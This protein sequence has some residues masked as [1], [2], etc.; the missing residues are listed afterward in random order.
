MYVGILQV[1]HSN[2]WGT[3][4]DDEWNTN[5]TRVVCRQLGYQH[6]IAKHLGPGSGRIWLD[7]VVCSGNENS[8]VNCRHRG[9]GVEDCEH[10]EDIG[11]ACFTGIKKHFLIFFLLDMH[12][13]GVHDVQYSLR[14]P[15]VLVTSPNWAFRWGHNP[16][17]HAGRLEVRYHGTWGTL[18][19]DNIDL[20]DGHVICRMMGYRQAAA[21]FRKSLSANASAIKFSLTLGCGGN[22]NSTEYCNT[23]KL[24]KINA[25]SRNSESW[26]VCKSASGKKTNK[27]G[28]HFVNIALQRSTE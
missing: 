15:Y 20:Q 21:V 8:I 13:T 16:F 14:I 2:E 22:E 9:W 25:C 5:N 4:C 7:D 12:R 3:V 27:Q 17:P 11:V 23:A 19:A 1:N 6:G 28:V 26:I 10:N 18:C 24:S